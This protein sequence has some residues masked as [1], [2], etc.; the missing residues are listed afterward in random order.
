MLGISSQLLALLSPQ[1]PTRKLF[2]GEPSQSSLLSCAFCDIFFFRFLF[3]ATT[4]NYL[5][6][7]STFSFLYPQNPF[8]TFLLFF[9]YI[10][11]VFVFSLQYVRLEGDM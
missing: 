5:P 1:L 2:V 6:C 7:T 8:F 3:P 4:T 9:V 10:P 11:R